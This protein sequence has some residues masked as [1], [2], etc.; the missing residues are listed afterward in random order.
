MVGA[1]PRAKARGRQDCKLNAAR[2][3]EHFEK[4][5]KKQIVNKRALEFIYEYN[6]LTL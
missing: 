5:M 4:G 3:L 1:F 6:G 2:L